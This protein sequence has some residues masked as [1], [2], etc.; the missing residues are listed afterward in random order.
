[1]SEKNQPNELSIS[2]YIYSLSK[3]RLNIVRLVKNQAML[4]KTHIRQEK[5]NNYLIFK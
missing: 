2:Y 1:M 4:H 3:N 5:K